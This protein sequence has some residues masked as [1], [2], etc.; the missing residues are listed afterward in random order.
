MANCS[1]QCASNTQHRTTYE[2]QEGNDTKTIE[3]TNKLR[4]IMVEFLADS[5]FFEEKNDALPWDKID[6]QNNQIDFEGYFSKLLVRMN[7]IGVS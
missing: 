3:Y 1:T 4:D 5:I 7:K 2:R 6:N